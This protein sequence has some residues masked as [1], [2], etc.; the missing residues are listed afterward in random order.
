MR[1]TM[2]NDGSVHEFLF[3]WGEPQ[4]V[5]AFAFYYDMGGLS[6]PPY[7]NYR[8]MYEHSL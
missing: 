7:E 8:V 2:T 5:R 6:W 1:S 4:C 3:S